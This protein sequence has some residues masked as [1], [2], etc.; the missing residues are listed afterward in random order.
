MNWKIFGVLLVGA[1]LLAACGAA[2][3]APA[4][5]AAAPTGDRETQKDTPGPVATEE[6][7]K[8]AAPTTDLKKDAV[9]HE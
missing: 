5:T 2:E 3:Q 6:T 8:P 1:G 9:L 7:K 4:A